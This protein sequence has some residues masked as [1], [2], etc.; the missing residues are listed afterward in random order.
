[1]SKVQI[2]NRALTGYLGES[3]IVSLSEENARARQCNLHY[4]DTRK[5]LLERHWWNFACARTTLAQLTNDR[6]SEWQYK[7]QLPADMLSVRWV[8]E[9]ATARML[10]AS[11]RSPDIERQV[12]G[13]VMY[14]DVDD[15]VAEYTQ[16][17]DD[18]TMFPQSFKDALSALLAANIAWP[19]TK[20]RRIA[21]NAMEQAD[22]AVSHA[23]AMDE[24][25]TP[26]WEM[27]VPGYLQVRGVT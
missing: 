12:E 26:P 24:R 9:P 16:D 25:N 23:I 27:A 20:D 18:E 10:L 6:T 15:A 7:Y 2:C 5:G 11:R 22:A 13:L 8:N 19:L 3:R 17:V 14:C 21:A 1:M 4:D